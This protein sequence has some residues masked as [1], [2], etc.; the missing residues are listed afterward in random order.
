LGPNDVVIDIDSEVAQA[1]APDEL[2]EDVDEKL[3]GGTMSTTLR[4]QLQQLV[5]SIPVTDSVSRVAE[6][7]YFVAASPE[8]AVQR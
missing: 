3:L 6:A 5:A 1:S 2:I 8:F 7:V 4:S